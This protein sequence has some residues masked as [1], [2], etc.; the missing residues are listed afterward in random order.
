MSDFVMG[1]E[2]RLTDNVSKVFSQMSTATKEFAQTISSVNQAADSF[3]QEVNSFTDTLGTADTALGNTQTQAREAASG[4]NEIRAA[5]QQFNRGFQ[6]LAELPRILRQAAATKMDAL[7]NSLAATK[8]QT[9][10]LVGALKAFVNTKITTAISGFNRF[11]ATVTEGKQ[12]LSGVAS[13][14]KNVA[15]LSIANTYTS[16]QKL[17]SS[18][19][20]FAS[21]K[22]SGVV[23]KLKEFKNN[24]TGGTNGTNKL[25]D[26]LKKAA[27]VSFNALHSGLSKVGSLAANAGAKI[28]KGFGTVA[29]STIKGFGIATAT[30]AAGAAAASAGIFKLTTMASD[31]D[32]TL[33]KTDVAFGDSST[34]VKAWSENS[35]KSMGLSK[36][37]ALD[38]TALFGDMGT[39]MGIPQNEAANMSMS[40]T[41]LGADLSSFKNIGIEEATT[42]LNGVFTGETESLKRLGIVMTQANLEQFAFSQGMTKGIKDMTEAEKVNLRYAYVMSKTA[43]AQGDFVRTGGGFANQLR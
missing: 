30:L 31:L 19:K 5:I 32:E 29:T 28:A 34:A 8:L 26:A 2:M 40:L 27:S 24:I 18:A 22:L 9:G 6:T 7:K 15:K 11:K 23:N 38:M 14:L 42:A 37:T 36:Q 4:I 13:A 16:M 1:A 35:I 12:G 3:Q 17:A 33:N 21:V 25:F 39:S 41:Q 20:D 10:L 43:N